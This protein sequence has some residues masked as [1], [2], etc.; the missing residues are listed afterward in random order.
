MFARFALCLLSMASALPA[1]ADDKKP[2][3]LGVIE[4][5]DPAFDALIPKDA[6]IE[7]LAGGFDWSEG[8]GLGARK[9]RRPRALLGH[10]QEHDLE[11]ER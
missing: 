2:M 4:R 3:T 1:L 9:G 8:A 5:K 10:P 6:V 11:V 7:I